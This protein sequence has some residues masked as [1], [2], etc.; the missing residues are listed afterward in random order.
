MF[1]FPAP[2]SLLNSES[3]LVRLETEHAFFLIHVFSYLIF[4]F[5]QVT[6]IFDSISIVCKSDVDRTQNK[7]VA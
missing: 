3:A 4:V 1:P 7:D 6:V 2:Y 5:V